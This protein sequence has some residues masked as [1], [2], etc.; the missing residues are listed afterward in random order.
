MKTKAQKKTN[1]PWTP[2]SYEDSIV[3]FIIL[4]F[5]DP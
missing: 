1:S 3:G 5:N 4:Y 2:I